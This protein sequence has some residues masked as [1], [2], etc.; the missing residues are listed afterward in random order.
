MLI[1]AASQTDATDGLTSSSGKD[2]QSGTT[3]HSDRTVGPILTHSDRTAGP[4][5]THSNPQRV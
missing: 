1:D 5:L 4:I 2:K 3:K